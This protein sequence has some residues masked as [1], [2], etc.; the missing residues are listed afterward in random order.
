LICCGS[1]SRLAAVLTHCW[2]DYSARREE[3][4]P[5]A[6]AAGKD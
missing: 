4:A 2:G 5:Q 1:G 3:I 6:I